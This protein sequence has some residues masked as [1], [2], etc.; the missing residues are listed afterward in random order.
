MKKGDYHMK[1]KNVG[2]AI[3]LTVFFGP[4][5]MLYSTVLGGI[6]MFVVNII[7]IAAVV[8]SQGKAVGLLVLSQGACITWAA[9]AANKHNKLLKEH[10]F[11]TAQS[12]SQNQNIVVNVHGSNNNEPDKKVNVER[13]IFQLAEE[14]DNVLTM[15]KIVSCIDIEIDRAEE[16]LKKYE[17][18]G[19]IETKVLENGK[20]Q[21]LFSDE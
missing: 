20:I 18:K 7:V 21:Y 12:Q 16:I 14:N 13:Q 3:I 10:G 1:E 9:I 17:D 5:G 19:L 2:V 15:K 6:I 4:L 11:G 8:A